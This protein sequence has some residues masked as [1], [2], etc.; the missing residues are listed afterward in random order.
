MHGL[1]MSKSQSQSLPLLKPAKHSNDGLNNA[2]AFEMETRWTNNA[3][4]AT[5]GQ[6]GEAFE[7]LHISSRLGSQKQYVNENTIAAAKRFANKQIQTPII[8][9]KLVRNSQACQK[10]R[11]LEGIH[12]PELAP[13]GVYNTNAPEWALG[14]K[15]RYTPYTQTQ[16]RTKPLTKLQIRKSSIKVDDS[17][18]LKNEVLLNGSTEWKRPRIERRSSKP[19]ISSDHNICLNAGLSELSRGKQKRILA[20]KHLTTE[21]YMDE[22]IA[23]MMVSKAESG[24]MPPHNGHE[25]LLPCHDCGSLTWRLAYRNVKE[26]TLPKLG[27]KSM[28]SWPIYL[29]ASCMRSPNNVDK[30]SRLRAASYHPLE[31]PPLSDVLPRKKCIRKSTPTVQTVTPPDSQQLR[32][33]MKVLKPSSNPRSSSRTFE[34]K[35][36]EDLKGKYEPTPKK[37][38]RI[39]T[40]HCVLASR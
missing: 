36:K 35:S 21:L 37:D 22:S 38:L 24:H 20:D 16:V 33:F 12:T 31:K 6:S 26:V 17:E 18:S 5:L 2:G 1:A 19:Y 23:A 34:A 13:Y 14:A 32:K 30:Y 9:E 8:F 7:T 28:H 11:K 25:W 10:P 39:E 15:N 40:S 4:V 29:C 3:R 27:R